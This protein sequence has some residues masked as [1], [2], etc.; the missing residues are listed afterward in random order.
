MQQ[1]LA[2]VRERLGDGLIGMTERDNTKARQ[3]VKIAL[4]MVID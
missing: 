3:G 2:L 1:I 4:A